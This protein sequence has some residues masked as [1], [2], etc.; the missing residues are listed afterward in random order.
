MARGE[1]EVPES[2]SDDEMEITREPGQSKETGKSGDLEDQVDSEEPEEIE[3]GEATHRLACVN[4]NWDVISAVD[5]LSVVR[6][7]CQGGSVYSV[8][9]YPSEYGKKQMVVSFAVAHK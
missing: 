8:T 7:F 4:L 5:L 3:D 1:I 2:S 6:S 9:I